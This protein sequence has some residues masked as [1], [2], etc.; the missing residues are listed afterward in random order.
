LI[1]R[2]VVAAFEKGRN[3][4]SAL[5]RIQDEPMSVSGKSAALLFK[6]IFSAARP[7]DR[8]LM[9]K[10]QFPANVLSMFL[11]LFG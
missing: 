2:L 8:V 7:I 1:L 10:S 3:R 6:S 11:F 9:L 4:S 5:T